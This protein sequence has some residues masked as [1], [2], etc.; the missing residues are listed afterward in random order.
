MNRVNRFPRPRRQ[1]ALS[2]AA[3]AAAL[4]LGAVPSAHAETWELTTGGSWATGTNWDPDG[5][6]NATG[7]SAI[8]TGINTIARTITVDSGASGFTVGSISLDTTGAGTFSNTIATGTTGSKLLLNNGGNGVTITTSGTGTGN[9][10]VAVP[11]TLSDNVNAVVNQTSNTST[12]GSLNL[13]AAMSGS[14]GFTKSGDGLASFGTGLK[15]YTG[16]TSLTGGRLRISFAA[17]PTSTSSFTINGGQLTI[18]ATNDGTYT[19][20]SGTLNL[21]GVGAVTGPFSAFPGAIRNDTGVAAVITNPVNLQSDTLLHV[22]GSATGSLGFTG[23]VTGVGALT[24][25]ALNSD[26]NLGKLVLSNTG[27]NYTGGTVVNGGTLDATAGSIGASTGPLTV[28][29]V[30]FGGAQTTVLLNSSTPT[31]TG[32]L[33]GT[34]N[35]NSATI[36]NGGQLFTVNQTTPGTYQGVITGA[37]GFT[38]GSLSTNTLTLS[39]NNS[40]SG[41]TSINGGTL[42]VGSSNNLGTGVPS[43]GI[44]F[45]GGTLAAT[46]TITSSR[47]VTVQAGGGTIDTGS[48]SVTVANIAGSGDLTKTSSG[49]LTANHYRVNNLSVAGIAKVAAI[50]NPTSSVSVIPGVSTVNSMTI[51]GKLNLTNNRIITNDAQGAESGGTYSGVLG[52]VQ[53]GRNGGAG[54]ITDEPLAAVNQTAI[55]VATAAEAKGLTGSAT[56]MWSGQTIDSNDTLVMYTWAG[57]ANLD[58]KVNAD[59]YASI[60]LYST[61]PGADTWNHGDFNYDGV[62]NADD[63]ALI[64]NNVQNVNYVPYWTTD[65]LRGLQSGGSATAGLT[66]VPEPASIGLLMVSA[67]GL[68]A[69]RRRTK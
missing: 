14:G 59:D 3:S 42:S 53:S 4:L 29:V 26:N 49:T 35:G 27:N 66:S 10:T 20:G 61:V 1:L 41:L 40:Y 13:T 37:G 6:P 23:L 64:D 19:F 52:M 43:N 69:S 7:A 5:V 8:F 36:N 28:N 68:M 25:T 15:S 63:Y 11:L 50:A 33:S 65:A 62:I 32:S 21:N 34:T 30:P 39:G 58:G 31:T 55:G 56:T 16:P 45:N 46:G 17:R 22:Q 18:T 51:S 38:L 54:I 9:N 57:D 47:N 60:D 12:A 2:L 44:S 48:N 24:L 67:A